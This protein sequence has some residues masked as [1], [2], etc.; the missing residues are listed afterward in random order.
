MDILSSHTAEGSERFKE[1][2]TT[3]FIEKLSLNDR[4]RAQIK[5]VTSD[6]LNVKGTKILIY[7]P[8]RKH[9]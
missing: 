7:M 4:V 2:I 3:F 1:D 6:L 8:K 9:I 5:K